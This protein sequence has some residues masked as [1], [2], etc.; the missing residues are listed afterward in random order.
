MG[1]EIRGGRPEAD[2][3]RILALSVLGNGLSNVER[4]C[5]TEDALSVQEAELSMERRLGADEDDMLITQ[6][7][8]A[9]TYE[10]IGRLEEALSLR[11]EVYSRRLKLNGEDPSTITAA[12]CYTS[13][14][15]ALKRFEEAKSLMRKTMPMARRVLGESHELTLRVS[16]NYA[17][18]LYKAD[19]AT[20]DD[21][22]AALTTLE[23]TERTARRV[24]GGAHPLTLDL[25]D[26]LQGARAT[27]S[28]RETPS[29]GSA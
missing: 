9:N 25:D 1:G 14:L 10:T 2:T 17:E 16:Y 3:A 27:L 22:H 20:L 12:I 28:A 19:S 11:Q 24:L 6:G 23:D 26:A 29:G 18:A 13:T 5:Q 15:K 4:V 21:R 7:N 8:L